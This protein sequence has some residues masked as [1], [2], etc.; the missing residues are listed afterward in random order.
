MVL[1]AFLIN[2][3]SHFTQYTEK[4]RL[5]TDLLNWLSR[6]KYIFGTKNGFEDILYKHFKSSKHA[7]FCIFEGKSEI[8]FQI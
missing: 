1:F 8:F 4:T 3:F 5:Y 6:L 2:S 7:I